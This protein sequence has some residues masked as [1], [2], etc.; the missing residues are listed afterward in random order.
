MAKGIYIIVVI[1]QFILHVVGFIAILA[2][3][4]AFVFGN[5]GRG[6]ELLIGG[7]CWLVIKYAIG[8]FYLLGLKLA[9]SGKSAEEI[10]G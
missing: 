1:L 9:G 3:I 4:V 10:G 6:K 7:I 8:A 5:S 2:G